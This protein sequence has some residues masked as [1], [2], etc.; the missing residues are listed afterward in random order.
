MLV[1]DT[2][3]GLEN[4][5][6]LRQRGMTMSIKSTTIISLIKSQNVQNRIYNENKQ[7]Q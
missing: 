3:I 4:I 2:D 5:L 1:A 7:L 6:S